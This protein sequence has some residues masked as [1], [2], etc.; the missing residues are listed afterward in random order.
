MQAAGH[1]LGFVNRALY[2]LRNGPAIRDIGLADPT[3]PVGRGPNPR[4]RSGR[5]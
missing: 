4:R 2:Q 5:R 1:P 3:D